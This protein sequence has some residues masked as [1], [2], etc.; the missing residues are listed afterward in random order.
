MFEVKEGDRI[1]GRQVDSNSAGQKVFL[2]LLLISNM[3]MYIHVL[4]GF[5]ALEII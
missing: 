4:L 2:L 3:Y 5:F 1:A